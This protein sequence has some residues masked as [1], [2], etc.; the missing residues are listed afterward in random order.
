[1][2]NREKYSEI[3][4][5]SEVRALPDGSSAEV[6]AIYLG[7]GQGYYS[8]ANGSIAGV[9]TATEEGWEWTPA[10]DAAPEIARVVA[11]LK[12]EEAAAFVQLPVE[13]Q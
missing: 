5:T 2:S 6:T 4:V 11:I 10:D 9:G 12:N 8:G 1:M 7:L 3:L 13:I